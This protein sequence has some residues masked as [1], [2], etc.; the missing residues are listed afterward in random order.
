MLGQKLHELQRL[1]N[2]YQNLINF[3]AFDLEEREKT[4]VSISRRRVLKVSPEKHNEETYRQTK[5][6]LVCG[7]SL[8]YGGHLDAG[9]L[10]ESCK[11]KEK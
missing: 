7:S 3:T 8:L 2:F 11:E 4:E 10:T 1:F 5:D 6:L 9:D